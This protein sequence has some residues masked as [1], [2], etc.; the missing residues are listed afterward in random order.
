MAYTSN[1]K[2]DTAVRGLTLVFAALVAIWLFLGLMVVT[3]EIGLTDL[4][5]FA[6]LSVVLLGGLAVA[7]R[8]LRG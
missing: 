4:T 7:A 2:A 8:R 6:A 1:P 5:D 3:G